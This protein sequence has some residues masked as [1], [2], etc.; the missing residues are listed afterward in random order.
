MDGSPDCRSNS[1]NTAKIKQPN[2]QMIGTQTRKNTLT[3]IHHTPLVL[4]ARFPGALPNDSESSWKRTS[5]ESDWTTLNSGRLGENQARGKF[6]TWILYLWK[7]SVC[8]LWSLTS[9][10]LKAQFTQE[11]K[12]FLIKSP[13]CQAKPVWLTFSCKNTKSEYM[14]NILVTLFNIMRDLGYQ[15]SNVHK[16]PKSITQSFK[17]TACK[18]LCVMTLAYV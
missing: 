8:F 6:N 7:P 2:T 14:K 3:C 9:Y 10:H 12:L 4:A 18:Q 1:W 13:T 17:K 15:T 11:W 16:S 5:V